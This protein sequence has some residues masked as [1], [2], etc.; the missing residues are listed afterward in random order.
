M[1]LQTFRS[2]CT[3][4]A[5]YLVNTAAVWT[6]KFSSAPLFVVIQL[7][8]YRTFVLGLYDLNTVCHCQTSSFMTTGEVAYAEQSMA[9]SHKDKAIR[10]GIGWEK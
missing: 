9:E 10:S 6:R 2:S 8:I 4:C 1:E 3:V 5:P 7:K